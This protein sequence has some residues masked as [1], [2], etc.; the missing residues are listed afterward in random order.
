MDN[1]TLLDLTREAYND[2]QTVCLPVVP[3]D[4]LRF[5]YNQNLGRVWGCCR[6]EFNGYAISLSRALCQNTNPNS[7]L[8]TLIHELIH[9]AGVHGHRAD[10][11]YWARKINARFPDK[12]NVSRCTSIKEKMTLEQA[13]AAYKYIIQCPEC[14]MIYGMQRRTRAVRSPSSYWCSVCSREHHKKVSLKRVK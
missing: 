5:L 7:I 4:K 10:F 3:W 8:N 12:Y 1:A 9:A 2:A 13:M 11:R 6:K 14:G